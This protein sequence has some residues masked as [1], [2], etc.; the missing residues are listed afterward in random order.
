MN[1]S[2]VQF[3]RPRPAERS[4]THRLH[5]AG[6][7]GMSLV[8]EITEGLLLES[9][10]TVSQQL[11]QWRDAGIQVALDDFGTGY[12]SLAYL[13][14]LEIDFIKIDQSFVHGLEA[15][16]TQFILCKAM[17]VMAHALGLR[18]VA[19][20]VE[21]AQQR[22]LLIEAGCDFAQGYF[23]SRPLTADALE[24]LLS[25]PDALRHWMPATTLHGMQLLVIDDHPIVRQ[26]MVAA[27]RQLQPGVEILEA[28]D[29][30]QG[31]ELLDANPRIQAV[32]VDLEMQPLGGLPTIRQIRQMQPALPVLVV[33]GSED[34]KDFH[35]A[36][37]AGAN[38]YCPKSAGLGT[39][40]QAVHQVLN[41]E[42]YRPAFMGTDPE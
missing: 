32:L 26:G 4:W 1:S 21:T 39:M 28:S 6:L 14:K 34:P 35:A 25:S 19:E 12:S 33:A 15:G 42:R 3:R 31:L 29:G 17:V 2:P 22:D 13:Q 5:A 8:V 24:S 41:G 11:L 7:P 10:D 38:G 18:V 9:S 36:M 20:G 30:A 27:L 37:H 40:R 23:F 16:G